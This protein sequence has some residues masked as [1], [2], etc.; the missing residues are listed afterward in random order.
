MYTTLL[1]LHPIHG[2]RGNYR[3]KLQGHVYVS[4]ATWKQGIGR[5]VV[6]DRQDWHCSSWRNDEKKSGAWRF[7]RL[8]KGVKGLPRVILWVLHACTHET[9]T[10]LQQALQGTKWQVLSPETH[11]FLCIT[12][13][14]YSHKASNSSH[15]SR[16]SWYSWHN[17]LKEMKNLRHPGVAFL[18]QAH[19]TVET[20]TQKASHF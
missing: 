7:S 17:M 11:F 5:V 9:S 3:K 13:P 10:L 4:R 19:W 16:D 14:N 20:R 18:L 12:F 1:L 8:E 15:L 6:F 2:L